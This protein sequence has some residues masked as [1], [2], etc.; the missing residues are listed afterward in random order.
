MWLLIIHSHFYIIL[1]V[2][3]HFFRGKK[4]YLPLS[5]VLRGKIFG[6]KKNIYQCSS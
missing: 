3:V 5:K 6:E 4:Y 1:W 2:N